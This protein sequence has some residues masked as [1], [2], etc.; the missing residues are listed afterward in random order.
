MYDFRLK[1]TTKSA[2]SAG[3]EIVKCDEK[4]DQ[5]DIEYYNKAA[6]Y[7][8]GVNPTIDGMLGGY[9]KISH[10][11]IEGSSKLLKLLFRE[12][13]GPE[14]GRALDCG[15]GI[16]R[17]TKHLLSK[18]FQTVDL[19]EQDEHFL[20]K[21]KEYLAGV[22]SVGNL[23]CAGL[24][25]FKFPEATYDVIW[26]QWVLGHLTDDHLVT[27]LTRCQSA[28][29]ARGV[30][31]V[32]ENVTSSGEVE[33]DEEDSSVTRPPQ[34]WKKLIKRA[35]LTI[36][37]EFKQNKFPKDIYEVHMFALRPDSTL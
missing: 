27:L 36:V 29:R 34:L 31:M 5:T 33:K 30:I 16:G 9:A 21:A 22:S 25:N 17:I 12:D 35:N 8:E 24:Q 28:L 2:T 14:K 23:F 10:I 26:F 4:N 18:H 15:A 32:K 7:W 3:V 6:S 1:M 13:S 37:K 20:V 19:V 11:D